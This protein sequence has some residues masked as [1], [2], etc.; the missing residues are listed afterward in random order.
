MSLASFLLLLVAPTSLASD[1]FSLPPEYKP[2]VAYKH[3]E[4]KAKAVEY[5]M[6]IDNSDSRT[7]VISLVK[8]GVSEVFDI[9]FDAIPEECVTLVKEN[10]F[11]KVKDSL[12]SLDEIGNK[13]S[14]EE[15]IEHAFSEVE[16]DDAA[17][18]K[19]MTWYAYKAAKSIIESGINKLG[20]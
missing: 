13:N 11:S 18:Y 4:F 5:S 14:M 12:T 7:E 20:E 15:T 9:L 10:V 6:K 19:K 16:A 17:S 3:L 8:D 2:Y 1:T